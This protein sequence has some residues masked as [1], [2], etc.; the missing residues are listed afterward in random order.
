MLPL[1]LEPLAPPVKLHPLSAPPALDPVA[2]VEVPIVVETLS[3]AVSEVLLPLSFVL[4]VLATLSVSMD[5]F[6][7]TFSQM[8]FYLT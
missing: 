4:I 8:T 7:L 2:Y 5:K 1:A 6:S 3:V